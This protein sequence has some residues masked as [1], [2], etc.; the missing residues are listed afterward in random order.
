MKDYAHQERIVAQTWNERSWNIY[1]D[2]GT[3][4]TRMALKTA[5]R[6]H[7]ANGIEGLFVIAPSGA[8]RN[9]PDIEIP[10]H[11]DL[12]YTT[13]VWS[14]KL[15][16]KSRATL[17]ESMRGP[18]GLD[19]PILVMNVEALSGKD[20]DALAIAKDFLQRQKTMM[21]VDESTSIRIPESM[22][23]KN[24]LSLVPYA[25]AYRN[26]SGFPNPERPTDLW[27]QCIA[28]R[29]PKLFPYSSWYAF[30]NHFCETKRITVPV[31]RRVQG[32]IQRV[33]QEI[34][35]ITGTKNV[36]ELHE[37]LLNFSSIIS[38]EDCLDLPPKTYQ[39][40]YYKMSEAQKKAYANLKALRFTTI[41][42]SLVTTPSALAQLGKLLAICAG[43]V[44]DDEGTWHGLGASGLDEVLLETLRE[45]GGKVVVWAAY[46]EQITHL[47]ALLR[48][49][50]GEGST[51][52][53]YGATAQDDRPEIVQRFQSP[54]NPLRFLVANPATGKFSWTLTTAKTAVYVSNQWEVEPR[55]QSEDRLHRIGQ[56]AKSVTYIDILPEGG[57]VATDVLNALMDKRNVAAE[58]LSPS[59]TANLYGQ[60]SL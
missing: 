29:R 50:F 33:M 17:L 42:E 38:K 1:G 45:E 43:F 14:S 57:T 23:T 52:A 8:Y 16:K 31:L 3:G 27:T 13:R 5:E 4:K 60:V 35:Q 39:R 10:K 41:G 24:V 36:E 11:L 9:W 19:L 30:R 58:I 12:G 34:T 44:R 21:V 51:E 48:K 47:V 22:R 20:N 46:T 25:T 26:L 7:A 6:L 59:W 15:S 2:T 53:F 18:S 56:E 40:R 54:G 49:E 37:L 28:L 32:R 55:H